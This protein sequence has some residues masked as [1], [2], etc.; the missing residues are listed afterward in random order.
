MPA[1]NQLNCPRERHDTVYFQCQGTFRNIQEEENN[2][3][4]SCQDESPLHHISD[5]K[6]VKITET[7]PLQVEFIDELPTPPSPPELFYDNAFTLAVVTSGGA[8]NG[9]AHCEFSLDGNLFVPFD[10]TDSQSHSHEQGPLSEERTYNYKIKCT[11]IAGNKATK[12]L[13]FTRAQDTHPPR[14]VWLTKEFNTLNIYL[15]EFSTCK[16]SNKNFN[17]EN[18]G[19]LMG[20]ETL[21]HT[22]NLDQPY[23]FI[24]CKD[25][26]DNLIDPIEVYA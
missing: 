26:F 15:N 11:D 9:V 2:F 6:L 8:E 19:T 24:K 10:Q 14:I 13:V 22:A 4:I 18:E 12:D 23:Y 5:P 20:S 16:Y 7:E 21:H 17:F 1:E 25:S 3:Y